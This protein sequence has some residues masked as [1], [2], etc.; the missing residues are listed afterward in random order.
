MCFKLE[1]D[2]HF[3]QILMSHSLIFPDVD[4]FSPQQRA[5]IA[6]SAQI[7]EIESG[8]H[9]FGENDDI[10]FLYIVQEGCVELSNDDTTRHVCRGECF[11]LETVCGLKHYLF[12][13][14]AQTRCVVAKIDKKDFFDIVGSSNEQVFQ[15]MFL[16]LFLKMFYG[17]NFQLCKKDPYQKIKR[18]VEGFWRQVTGWL[19]A[20]VSPYVVFHVLQSSGL[21]YQCRM[22]LSIITSWSVISAFRL[23]PNHVT[24]MAAVLLL[25]GG[26]VV[27][28]QVI[29]SGFSSS[30]FVVAIALIGL[31]SVF[32]SSGVAYR[33][34]IWLFSK[35]KPSVWKDNFAL[36]GSGVLLCMGFPSHMMRAGLV[37]SFLKDTLQIR[38][39]NVYSKQAQAF[40][41]SAYCGVTVL[42]Q[43]ILSASMMHFVFLGLFWKQYADQFDWSGWLY[44]ALVPMLIIFLGYVFLLRFSFN[45]SEED[46]KN[47]KDEVRLENMHR[48]LGKMSL[49]EV[50]SAGGM[51]FV[52]LGLATSNWHNLPL[53][54][55][56][57][58]ILLFLLIFQFVSDSKFRS[59]INWEL[60]I[61]VCG[62]SGL[63]YTA[64]DIGLIKWIGARAEWIPH[65]FH[66]HFILG[67]TFLILVSQISQFLFPRDVNINLLCVVL[68]PLFQSN[69]ISPWVAVYTVATVGRMPFFR[70]Q[71]L[72]F[73]EFVKNLYKDNPEIASRIWRARVLVGIFSLA[74][75][76]VGIYYWRWIGV[77]P[78]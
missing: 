45:D 40:S 47:F 9:F 62:L 29:L 66:E 38:Q 25:V 48:E 36:F 16:Q 35:L 8:A 67:M 46:L 30:S 6:A 70:Y 51:G 52:I 26:G 75:I 44:A 23:L 78:W 76:Y 57:L 77:L 12:K 55:I 18:Y 31:S 59:V 28:T 73:H 74:S 19:L 21:N 61:F 1:L 33:A 15:K 42:A 14:Q 10:N 50:V 49:S 2:I 7:E 13:A 58:T 11:G 41:F 27:K 3:T 39:I 5:H 72:E 56:C 64:N 54:M 32:V 34:L 22:F 4:F 17:K 20:A 69:G 60:L 24:T 37:R 68:I 43:S 71:E 53:D 63:G 65:Y